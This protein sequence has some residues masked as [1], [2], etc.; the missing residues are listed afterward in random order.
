MAKKLGT[1]LGGLG[2]LI[3]AVALLLNA[4][5][6]YILEKPT[7]SIRPEGHVQST[8]DSLDVRESSRELPM[9]QGDN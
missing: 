4:L 6:P 8:R 3:T 9:P 7:P 1:I 2:G 5:Q